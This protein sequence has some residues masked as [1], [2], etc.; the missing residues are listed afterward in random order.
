MY[1]HDCTFITGIFYEL[2][3]KDVA[4][5]VFRQG[6]QAFF[7]VLGHMLS[8]NTLMLD[9]C[10]AL[11]APMRQRVLCEA[12]ILKDDELFADV[13]LRWKCLFKEFRSQL[14]QQNSGEVF[15]AFFQWHMMCKM[16]HKAAS[17]EDATQSA[18]LGQMQREE[19]LLRTSAK[20]IL[21]DMSETSYKDIQKGLVGGTLIIDYIFFAPLREN[22]LLD[23]YCV[24]VER[25]GSPIVCELNYK[26]IRNQAAVV[27]QHLLSQSTSITQEKIDC[28]L[29]L[30]SRVLFPRE[31]LDILASGRVTKLYIS[32]D[33]DIAHIPF[34]SLPVDLSGSGTEIPL[35]EKF[36]IS[37]VSSTRK[38]SS[39]N[40]ET[41]SDKPAKE[42]MCTIIGN[43][44]FDLC[45][46]VSAGGDSSSTVDKLINFICGYFSISPDQ[47]GPTVENLEHSKDEVDFISSHLRS[48]GLT[49]QS[50]TGDDATLRKVLSL[51]SPLLIHISSHAHGTTGRSV[52]AYRGSF[53]DDL[54]SAAVVLAGFN[55][56][57]RKKFDQLPSDCGPALLSPLAIFSMKLKGTKLVFLSAC[58]SSAGKAPIQEAV[59][60]LAEAFLTAGAE[61]VIAALWP[62]ADKSAADISKLFYEKVTTPGTRPSDALTHAKK[63]VMERDFASYWSNCAAFVCHGIDKPLFM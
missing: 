13:V 63:T 37:I 8:T 25:D 18:L 58:S 29:S 46:P 11:L 23:A 31:L 40:L 49:V 2:K 57:S 3:M 36:S 42:G 16:S 44:N 55:T 54:K 53:F 21:A 50:M 20:L 6:E 59:D 12:S 48:R 15:S 19:A 61:T 9:Q 4:L 5:K 10:P 56:F 51:E 35:F 62:I 34:D 60:S 27:A 14:I 28:E 22:P 39:S 43:P 26:A 33:S 1:V 30:L 52:Q 38:L 32:P 47:S 7:Q 17:D 41:D 45:M 24:I